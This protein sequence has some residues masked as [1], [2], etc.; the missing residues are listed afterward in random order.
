MVKAISITHQYNRVSPITLQLHLIL[1]VLVLSP[2]CCLPIHLQLPLL[3]LTYI[4][5]QHPQLSMDLYWYN[6]ISVIFPLSVLHYIYLMLSKCLKTLSHVV[7]YK[8]FHIYIQFLILII[9]FFLQSP[10]NVQSPIIVTDEQQPGQLLYQ[11][12]GLV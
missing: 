4:T 6:N 3:L 12:K 9:L 7:S 8:A 1:L 2:L 5:R 10:S 11:Y